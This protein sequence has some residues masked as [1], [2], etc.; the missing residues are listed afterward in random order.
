MPVRQVS[1]STVPCHRCWL[2]FV[3]G[4][5][6]LKPIGHR[7]WAPI[8]ADG[9][10]VTLH[11]SPAWQRQ[12][13]KPTPPPPVQL[14]QLAIQSGMLVL[15]SQKTGMRAYLRLPGLLFLQL[16]HGGAAPS[17]HP[18]LSLPPPPA[19]APLY[20]LPFFAREQVL[21]LR[22]RPPPPWSAIF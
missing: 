16:R 22:Q 13:L 9:P 8:P 7:S 15:T 4:L 18:V 11:S 14:E 3:T 12:G 6:R 17:A 21:C 19:V 10:T 5:P 1:Q 2:L 20:G